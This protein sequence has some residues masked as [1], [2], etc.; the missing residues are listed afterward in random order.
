MPSSL[1]LGRENHLFAPSSVLMRR[2]ITSRRCGRSQRRQLYTEAGAARRLRRQRYGI[3]LPC[4]AQFCELPRRSSTMAPHCLRRR[5]R[6][7]ITTFSGLTRHL[8]LSLPAAALKG[9]R[10]P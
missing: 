1:P 7:E 4:A 5:R 3:T 2:A 6:S 8:V 9:R 10:T